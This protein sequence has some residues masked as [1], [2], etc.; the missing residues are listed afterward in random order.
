MS[1][2]LMNLGGLGG[3]R[4]D[5]RVEAALVAG[6]GVLVEDALLHALIKNRYGGAIGLGGGLVVASG[7]GLAHGAEGAAELGLVGAIDGRAGDGLAGALEGRNVICHQKLSCDPDLAGNGMQARRLYPCQQAGR[8]PRLERT[9][10]AHILCN[11]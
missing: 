5:T 3:E 2:D 10:P 4:F 7:D 6:G 11:T 8:G 9:Q 1:R